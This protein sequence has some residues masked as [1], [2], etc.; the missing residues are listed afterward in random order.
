MAE[1]VTSSRPR[2]SLYDHRNTL[3]Q[4]VTHPQAPRQ[5]DH[6]RSKL[7]GGP[8]SGNSYPFSKNSWNSPPMRQSVI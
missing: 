2:A 8:N 5:V 7:G 3:A 6:K 1:D 4:S